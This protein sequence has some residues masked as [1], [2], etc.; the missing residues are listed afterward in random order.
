M[1]W[2]TNHNLME[3]LSSN[4]AYSKA[5]EAFN[6]SYYDQPN[7]QKNISERL[8]DMY[9][10]TAVKRSVTRTLDIVKELKT[11][12]KKAPDKIF[13]EMARGE[14]DT[15]KGKRTQSR[16][17]QINKFLEEADADNISELKQKLDTADDG[18]LRSEK[19]YLYFMQLGRC[20]YTGK[21]INFEELEDN[22]KWNIDHIWPQAKIKDES[23]DN[24]VLVDT[25]ENGKKS[26][27]YPIDSEI[28]EK[29]HGF[30]YSLREKK[31]I[32]EKKY[33]RLVRSTPF[34]EEEL[35]GFIAR[36]LVETRQSTKAVATI[37]KELF[38]E[39]DI[40]YVKAG[41]VSEFRQEMDMLK[42]REINDF[43]HAKDAYLN[44]VMGNIYDTK[45]TKSPLNFV[46]SGER[47]SMKLFKKDQNNKESGLLTGIVKRGDTLAWD[48]NSSFKIV[49]DMMAKNSIRYVRYCYK[50]KGGFFNQMPE[51]KKA[52][53]VP[54]K[55]GLNTEKYGGYNNATASFFSLIKLK[56][57]IIFVPISL[58]DANT[59][60]CDT[61]Q[62]K[63]IIMKSSSVDPNGKL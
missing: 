3:L 54:R 46:K 63:R 33:S 59:F 26:D 29:M 15:P 18:K 9:I 5:I 16:R 61:K 30:W 62:A 35:S 43:H 21:P 12:L 24:K 34:T 53:L 57:D 50:R 42:C 19:Y 47:Y 28:R 11:I 39:T 38:P 58:L 25:N 52:G 51:R 45:F 32:S 60:M 1:L 20:A 14:G 13:I 41:I 23:L 8:K 6:K 4:F 48:P 22:H 40:V 10:P 36:Q 55:N 7:H 56:S 2:E 37:L 31:L 27:T 44:I 17:D 49:R